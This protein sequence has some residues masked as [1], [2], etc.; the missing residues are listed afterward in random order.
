ML[1]SWILP[2]DS[3]TFLSVLILE[4]LIE[5]D[6]VLGLAGFFFFLEEVLVSD[7]SS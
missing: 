3:Y 2:N 1:S 5:E 6:V 7:R 4:N